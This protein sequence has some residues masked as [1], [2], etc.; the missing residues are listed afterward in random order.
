MNRLYLLADEVEGM[1]IDV[2]ISKEALKYNAT[3]KIAKHSEL[4][5]GEPLLSLIHEYVELCDE[6]GESIGE[7]IGNKVFAIETDLSTLTKHINDVLRQY[8]GRG[9]QDTDI[10]DDIIGDMQKS[11][12]N[13]KEIALELK[14]KK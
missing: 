11:I 6:K 14:P 13:L 3:K 8:I 5:G 10:F 12:E 7:K 2:N 9:I 4:V 1:I